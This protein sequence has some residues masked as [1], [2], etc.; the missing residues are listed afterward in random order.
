MHIC[1][2]ANVYLQVFQHGDLS[3]WWD[4]IRNFDLDWAS[5]RLPLDASLVGAWWRAGTDLGNDHLHKVTIHNKISP[6]PADFGNSKT[7]SRR[8]DEHVCGQKHGNKHP[9]LNLE[10]ETGAQPT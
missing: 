8:R 10:P 2:C 6:A 4:L 9:E 7:C 1:G 3:D 5:S